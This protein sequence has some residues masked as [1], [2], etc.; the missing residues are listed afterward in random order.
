MGLCYSYVD[1]E[2][3]YLERIKICKNLEE[4]EEF[5]KA[6][7][8]VET[9]G[10]L[11]HVRM[12]LDNY[13]SYINEDIQKNADKYPNGLEDWVKEN[14][15]TSAF[16]LGGQY[17]TVNYDAN[18]SWSFSYG[19]TSKTSVA[20]VPYGSTI[21][22]GSSASTLNVNGTEVTATPTAKSAEYTYAFS[23]WTQTSTS[24]TQINTT[25]FTI[26]GATTVYANFTRTANS[27]T[28]TYNANGGEQSTCP[29]TQIKNKGKK[30]I[31]SSIKPEWPGTNLRFAGW[32]EDPNA[33]SAEYPSGGIY[34][35]DN[36]KNETFEEQFEV[37]TENNN[38]QSYR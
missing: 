35:K 24:G 8:W 7:K 11:R 22:V 19:S 4:M 6:F 23:K 33:T 2:Y 32:S 30:L 31:L 29:P 3:G 5:L 27:Y 9:N 37:N 36:T 28:V 21:K 34:I 15:M 38:I 18:V 10:K 17:K 25:G 20:S 13:E 14:V 1:E 12:I 26:T 16:A